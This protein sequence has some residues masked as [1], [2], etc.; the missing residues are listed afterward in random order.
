MPW[1]TTPYEVAE[2]SR[3]NGAGSRAAAV[4]P[5]ARARRDMDDFSAAMEALQLDDAE[6]GEGLTAAEV[7]FR[8][9]E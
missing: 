5:L 7:G 2:V 8:R 3:S 1:D 6:Q 9:D 4:D